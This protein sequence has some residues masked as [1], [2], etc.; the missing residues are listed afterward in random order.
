MSLENKKHPVVEKMIVI[1]DI[2]EKILLFLGAITVAGFLC[3]VFTDVLFRTFLTPLVWMEEISR[4]L[5]LWSIFLGSAVAFRRGVHFKIDIIHIKNHTIERIVSAIAYTISCLFVYIILAYGYEFS[6]MGLNKLSLP[7]GIP[8]FF[9]R[10]SFPVSGVFMLYYCIEG[11]V[12][13][14]FDTVVP[15]NK[16]G[17]V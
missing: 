2:G 3:T 1:G 4:L 8:L 17:E 15:A 5:Y 14:I 10:L 11:I 12:K 16:N 9:F 7:S 6:I 13:N